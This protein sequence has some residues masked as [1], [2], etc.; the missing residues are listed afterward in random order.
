ML[1][2]RTTM[3]FIAFPTYQSYIFHPSLPASAIN[4]SPTLVG[5]EKRNIYSVTPKTRVEG[6]GSL[7]FSLSTGLLPDY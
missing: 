5:A 6:N 7:A 4:I 3:P 1:L 2:L